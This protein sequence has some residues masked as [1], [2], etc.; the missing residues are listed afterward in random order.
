MAMMGLSRRERQIMD[1][2]YQLGKASASDVREAMKDAPS[3]STERARR[4]VAGGG[5]ITET[6]CSGPASGVDGR[7]RRVAGAAFAFARTSGFARPDRARVCAAWRGL[8]DDG[9]GVRRRRRFRGPSH[10]RCGRSCVVA[11]LAP[12]P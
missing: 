12:R 11:F 2:L 7:I 6:L 9:V 8:S 1:I 5:S 4:G 10:D 3:Y